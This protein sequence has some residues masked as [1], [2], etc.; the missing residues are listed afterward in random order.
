M[1]MKVRLEPIPKTATVRVTVA[2]STTLNAS[3]DR[4]AHLHTQTQG[5]SVRIV[6]IV[7]DCGCSNLLDGSHL[8][9]PDFA[10]ATKLIN[11]SN[12]SRD[13]A[14]AGIV[15]I[16]MLFSVCTR[17]QLS[18]VHSGRSEHSAL[19]TSKRMG[20]IPFNFPEILRLHRLQCARC[21]HRAGPPH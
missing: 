14:L 17:R 18:R 1:S 7:D 21:H 15:C 16:G 2:L 9:V 11:C 20:S 6:A 8:D 13:A 4:Y 3:L 19:R 10:L 5:A 12:R